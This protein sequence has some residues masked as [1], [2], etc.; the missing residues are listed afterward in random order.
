MI[1]GLGTDLIELARIEAALERHGGA[2]L[3][4]LFTERESRLLSGDG[5]GGASAPGRHGTGARP[6]TSRRFVER[7]GARFAAKEAALKALGTGWAQG[8]SWHHVE[9]LGGGGEAPRLEFSG[10]ARARME[11]LGARAALV[12]L[13]HTET[14]ASATVVLSD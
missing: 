2:L 7:V 13:T 10:R 8:I 14:M 5:R 12:S 4:R 6:A 1:L 3:E 9:V 11:S